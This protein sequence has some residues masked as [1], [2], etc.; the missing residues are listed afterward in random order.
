MHEWRSA[1]SDE[2]AAEPASRV[3]WELHAAGEDMTRL[4]LIHDR[5]EDSPRTAQGVGGAG[6]MYVASSL[7]SYL[8][9]GAGLPPMR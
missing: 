6:W 2:L 3:T 8:E 1:Y 9:T 4:V 7:K 5:L